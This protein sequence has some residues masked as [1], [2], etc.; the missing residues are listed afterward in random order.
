MNKTLQQTLLSNWH[1]MRWVALTI[2]LF[3]M[4]MG[5]WN[6]DMVSVLLGGFFLFQAVTNTGCLCGNCAVPV[7]DSVESQNKKSDNVEFTEIKDN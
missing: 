7:Q 3:F 6:A 1:P 5:A 4:A 2:G